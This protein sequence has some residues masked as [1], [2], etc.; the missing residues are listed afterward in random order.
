MKSTHMFGS[1]ACSAAFVAMVIFIPLSSSI[2]ATPNVLTVKSNP[3]GSDS[4]SDRYRVNGPVGNTSSMH[5]STPVQQFDTATGIFI[6]AAIEASFRYSLVAEPIHGVQGGIWTSR[7]TPQI[8]EFVLQPIVGAAVNASGHCSSA[9]IER[10]DNVTSTGNLSGSSDILPQKYSDFIGTG[11]VPIVVEAPGN[12]TVMQVSNG[13]SVKSTLNI[14]SQLPHTTGYIAAV[15][16]YIDFASP[17]FSDSDPSLRYMTLD[18]GNLGLNSNKQFQ[19]FSISNIG[20]IHSAGV[21]LKSVSSIGSG[22]S[23]PLD[24]FMNLDAGN[25]ITSKIQ[26]DT[27]KVGTFDQMFSFNFEDYVPGGIGTRP[28]QLNLRAIGTVLAPSVPEPSTWAM[29]IAGFGL[30]GGAIRRRKTSV[31]FA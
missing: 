3:F 25:T 2:A 10:C 22:F 24:T 4:K 18:F 30:V 11:T 19:N 29:M 12:S 13:P 27:S 20:D 15:Y 28:Y 31:S 8:S 16:S 26:F 23:N 7:Y 5:I 14:G 1:K 17:S 9:K 21:S 6:S